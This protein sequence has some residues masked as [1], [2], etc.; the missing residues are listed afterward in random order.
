MTHGIGLLE[1]SHV[2]LKAVKVLNARV[3]GQ[4]RH[5]G[6]MYKVLLATITGDASAFS[7]QSTFAASVP[8]FQARSERNFLPPL[9]RYP[10]T[11]NRAES[12]RE[13]QHLQLYGARRRRPLL[14][15]EK[16][17]ATPVAQERV[18]VA[19]E[20]PAEAE[21]K[22]GCGTLAGVAGCEEAATGGGRKPILTPTLDPGLLATPRRRLK[23]LQE[24]S[25]HHKKVSC[26]TGIRTG[27]G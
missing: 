8:A 18:A 26:H 5:E 17:C 11:R 1:G 16:T 3:S 7:A 19:G 14:G 13:D 21:A 2:A 25:D 4:P 12:L 27:W 22:A 20:A 24:S 9:A 23:V 10:R 15:Q 6:T